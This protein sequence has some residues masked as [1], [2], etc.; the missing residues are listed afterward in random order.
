MTVCPTWM[1]RPSRYTRK[2]V[3]SLVE[4]YLLL[5]EMKGTTKFGLSILVRLADL[6]RAWKSLLPH[7]YQAVLLHG[8]MRLPLRMVAE[9]LHVGS[10]VTILNRYEAGLTSMTDYLNG[11]DE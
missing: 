9:L 1:S 7:E 8:L 3:Q 2:E 6:D 5:R 4:G 11:D 10:Q